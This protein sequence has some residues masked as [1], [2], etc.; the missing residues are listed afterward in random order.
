MR[1]HSDYPPEC[2]IYTKRED[3]SCQCGVCPRRC[4]IPSGGRG[5]CR[6]RKNIDGTLYAINYGRILSM[7]VSPIEKKPLFHFYPGSIWISMGTF[8][9]NF[10]CPGC[11]NWSMSHADSGGVLMSPSEVVRY[12]KRFHCIGISWTYNEPSVWLE[13]IIDS[14]REARSQHLLTHLVTNGYI[15]PEALDMIGPYIDC[16]RVDIK[17]FSEETYNRIGGIRDF[18]S[19]LQATKLA[20]FKWGMHVECVTNIIS[21][22]NDSEDE[23]SNIASWISKELGVDTPWHVTRFFPQ[24]KL[25]GGS[26]TPLSTLEMAQKIGKEKGLLYVY[27]GNID[28]ET[29]TVCPSCNSLLIERDWFSIKRY[30]LSGNKC[31]LCGFT[32]AGRFPARFG[33]DYRLWDGIEIPLI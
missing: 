16:F 25:S 33:S 30:N 18:A 13:F 19:I 3:G 9:C 17:G 28:D 14:A 6:G 11:Q 32:I 2:L 26:V 12:A 20:K 21:G 1:T 10:K 29:K 5:F 15:T 7:A 27:M 23:L 8:G 31:I 22:F 24:F 4:I